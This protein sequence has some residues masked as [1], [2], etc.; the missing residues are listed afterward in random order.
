MT[1]NLMNSLKHD[2]KPSWTVY[3]MTFSLAVN[4]ILPQKHLWC[5]KKGEDKK[6]QVSEWPKD[7]ISLWDQEESY[8]S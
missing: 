8:T 3:W 4:Y 6:V 5:K 2:F 7:V 1:G